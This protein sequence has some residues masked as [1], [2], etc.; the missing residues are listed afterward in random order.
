MINKRFLSRI[1]LTSYIL[2]VGSVSPL[3]LS[4]PSSAQTQA[5]DELYYTFFEQKIPLTLRSDAIAVAFKPVGRT[6]GTRSNKPLHLQL[7]QDLQKGAG[8]RGSTRA[9]T[10]KVEV[11][12][13]GENYALVNFPPELAVLQPPFNSKFSSNPM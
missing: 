12:P 6:R 2:G 5:S 3:L 4:A 10:L 1:L 11:S 9:G 13:L 8:T 7:Q